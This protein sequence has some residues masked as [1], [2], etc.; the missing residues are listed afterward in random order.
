MYISL[1]FA[2]RC[3]NAEDVGRI[4]LIVLRIER[5]MTFNLRKFVGGF[6]V[7]NDQQLCLLFKFK[8][9]WRYS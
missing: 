1:M 2:I 8:L 4:S 9:Q 6:D 5:W 7:E 3:W